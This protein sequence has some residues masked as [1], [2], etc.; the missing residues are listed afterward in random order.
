MS[1]GGSAALLRPRLISLSH[2]Q[3]GA[4]R[5]RQKL[6]QLQIHLHPGL[7]K[8][9]PQRAGDGVARRPA[10]AR[11]ADSRWQHFSSTNRA[12]AYRKC[13]G[14][15]RYMMHG[16]AMI[17]LLKRQCRS[18]PAQPTD[19][20]RWR[21]Q[22]LFQLRLERD[23][24]FRSSLGYFK[25]FFFIDVPLSEYRLSYEHGCCRMRQCTLHQ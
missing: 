21:A 12:G 15:G 25:T 4:A 2:L 13:D 24:L 8:L 11:P 14:S 20:A 17:F 6:R 7:T 19:C 3:A 1:T 9:R 23:N 22:F 16:E 18:A 10:A 5:E